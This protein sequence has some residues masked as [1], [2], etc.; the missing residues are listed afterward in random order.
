MNIVLKLCGGRK[1][2]SF[3]PI[4]VTFPAHDALGRNVWSKC[5][6]EDSV[7]LPRRSCRFTP[8]LSRGAGRKRTRFKDVG[9][10]NEMVQGRGDSNSVLL[11][12]LRVLAETMF[13]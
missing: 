10:V 1:L 7:L 5:I 3:I 13:R 11:A 2:W 4:E 8:S 9:D 6:A 12:T